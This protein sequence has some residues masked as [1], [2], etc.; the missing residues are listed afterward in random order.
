MAPKYKLCAPKYLSLAQTFL[1]HN[2]W[3]E[4]TNQYFVV[5]LKTSPFFKNIN[6][7]APH[8]ENVF[9]IPWFH[10]LFN[11]KQLLQR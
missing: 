4:Q 2:A 7:L 11:P 10:C 6:H 9:L 1:L 5:S 3:E 8:R